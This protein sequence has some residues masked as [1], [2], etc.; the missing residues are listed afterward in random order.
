MLLFFHRWRRP[1]GKNAAARHHLHPDNPHLFL[2]GQRKQLFF[3]AVIVFVCRIDAHKNG[4]EWKAAYAFDGRFWTEAA[5]HAKMAN[6][7]RIASLDQGF[8]C[9]TFG[10]Y[11]VNVVLNSNSAALQWLTEGGLNRLRL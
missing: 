5:S 9:A 3:K 7:L 1:T 6:R 2:D 4:V 11:L 8:D 10:K